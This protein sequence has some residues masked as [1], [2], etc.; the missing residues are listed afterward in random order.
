LFDNDLMNGATAAAGVPLTT[1]LS[2]DEA[3][4]YFLWDEPMT[5][6]DL[7]QRLGNSEGERIRLLGKILREARDTDVWLF[8]TVQEVD[9]R[10]DQLE[11]HLGR[12]RDFW[13][14]L[15]DG[16]RELGLLR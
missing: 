7:R 10:W 3:I 8:T 15:L 12:R 6:R 14:F 2:H 13:R 1:D 11:R 4:P 16:W 9:Q 5:I